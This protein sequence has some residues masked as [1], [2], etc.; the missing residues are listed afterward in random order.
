MKLICDL[1]G[2]D[3]TEINEQCAQCENCGMEYG[4]ERLQEMRGVTTDPEPAPIPKPVPVPKPV[5][6]PEPAPIPKPVPTPKP[7]PIPEPVSTPK[8]TPILEPMPVS[9]PKPEPEKKNSGCL[10]WFLL[11]MAVADLVV[12]THGIVA[13]FCLLIMWIIHRCSQKK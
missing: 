1:C 10:I 9:D 13:V 6:T 2:G 7:T 11:I 4:P 12:G 3:L 5:P 8:P